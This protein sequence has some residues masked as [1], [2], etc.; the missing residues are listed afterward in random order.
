MNNKPTGLAAFSRKGVVAA[1][2]V[3][4]PTVEKVGAV[5]GRGKKEVVALTVRL[6]RAQWERLHQLAAAEGTSI[7][8]LAVQGL[9]RVFT[10]RGLPGLDA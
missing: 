5:R 3:D 9:S 6:P 10:E 1:P 7:Q 4:E 8:A 2:Q